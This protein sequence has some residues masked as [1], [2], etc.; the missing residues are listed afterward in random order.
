MDEPIATAVSPDWHLIWSDE[1]TGEIGSPPD[2]N[3]WTPAIG[4]DGWGNQELQYYTNHNAY[5]DGHSH[6]VIEVRQE[7]LS[8][9]HGWYG[10]CPYTS[11]RLITKDKFTLTY[12]RV[13]AYIQFPSGQGIW[14]GF[15]ML[16]NDI[17]TVGWPDNGEIDIVEHIGREPTTIHATVHGPNNADGISGAYSLAAGRFAD[18]YHRFAVDWTPQQ[19]VFWVDG[20]PYFKVTKS[21]VEQRGKWVYDHPFYLLLN[22]AVGGTWPGNPDSSST[23][24]QRLLVDYIRVYQLDTKESNLV[25]HACPLA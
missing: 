10:D 17:D 1:F 14:P 25:F 12:G 6:L 21:M 13:E 18:G 11:A 24:P 4:G 5:Q 22:V 15:W 16:G 3:T 19:I 8:P 20:I 9:Y 7:P 23:Y 2:V